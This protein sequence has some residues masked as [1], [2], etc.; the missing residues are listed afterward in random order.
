MGSTASD[1]LDL[2]DLL[3][4]AD[5]D[6]TF[7]GIAALANVSL[8]V[9]KGRVTA[10]IGPNGAG[11]TT[12]FNVISGFYRADRG[13]V[14]FDG[15]DLLNEPAHTRS[16]AGIA[17]T[18]QNIA[19][20]PGLTVAENI[21][22]GAHSQLRSGVFTSA[23]YL[24]R[25]AGEERRI[26][27]RINSTVL[28]LLGLEEVRDRSV[29]GLPYGFQKR[30]E[31]ARALISEPRLLMLDEPFAGLNTFEKARMAEQ[32]RDL[33]SQTSLT[34]LLI[35]HDMESIMKMSDQIVVLNFGRVIASGTP[36][37]VQG[38]PAVVEAYLGAE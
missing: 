15:H 4:V 6:V 29:S 32:I 5:I 9:P 26:D 38:D 33:A 1:L 2:P 3:E 37:Q 20:F 21:K 19:L 8:A 11:K 30:I 7:G 10:V 25:A 23:V 35:D 16:R 13:S 27:A 24:G 17:R 36:A 14:S 18:F 28:P 12:L 31:L 34:V 22:L